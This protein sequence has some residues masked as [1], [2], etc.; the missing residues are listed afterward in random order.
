MARRWIVVPLISLVL[1]VAGCSSSSKSSTTTTTGPKLSGTLT[2]SGATFPKLFYQAAIQAYGQAQ[3][4]LKI[5]YNPTGSGAGQ[6]DLQ[7]QLVNFAGSDGLIK[8]ADLPKY[9]GGKVLYFPTVAAPITVSYNLN[10][11]NNLQL[12]PD[13]LAKIFMRTVK[14]WNDPAIATDNP[15]LALPSIPITVARRSDSSGTTENF[16]KYLVA[17]APQ[18]WKLGTGKTV[19]W[20][21]DTSA[22]EGNGGVAK[23][24]QTQSGAI[25]YVDL[26][27]AK[28]ANLATAKIKNQDGNFV[29]PTLEAASAALDGATI[30]PDLTYNPLNAKGK[31]SYPITAPTWLLVYQ[32]QPDANTLANLKGF[33]TFLLTTGQESAA[34]VNFARLP[35]DLDR[36]AIA[37]LSQLNV[38]G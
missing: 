10:G 21:A 13:T 37:Q 20:A 32:T 14:T 35:G 23:V 4:E 38:K 34:A 17:A 22:G 27:D 5:T 33:L 36:Q 3:P 25:G 1:V 26:G 2:G 28:A 15:G 19:A 9:S 31:D 7:N 18:D 30:N 24:I 11:V 6:T 8:E 16:T 29:G 12:A